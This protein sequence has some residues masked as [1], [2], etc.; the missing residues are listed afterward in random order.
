MNILID[1]VHPAHVHFFK[2]AIAKWRKNGHKVQVVIR[3]K[4]SVVELLEA[5]GIDYIKISDYQP[6]LWGLLKELIGRDI[7]LYKI[8]KKFKPDIMA[9]I[10]GFS[11]SFLGWLT[12]IPAVILTDTEHARLSNFISFPFAALICTPVSFQEDAGKKQLRYNGSHELA[13]LHPDFFTPDKSILNKAGLASDERFFIVRFVSWGAAHDVGEQ[14][15]E[16]E[17]RLGFIEKLSR[18]GKALITSEGKLPDELVKYKIK[19]A[20]QEIH[21]LLYYADLYIGESPTMASEAGVLGTPSILISSWAHEAGCIMEQAQYGI[22]C[23]FTQYEP[24]LKKAIEL[25]GNPKIK[26]KWKQ[27]SRKMVENKISVTPWLVEL[28]EGYAKK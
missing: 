28:V 9:G 16:L 10:A 27:K 6:G 21:H 19:V 20:P 15:I 8:I 11:I 18:Y 24:A 14:G 22:V 1:I 13:Y 3:Q 23:P 7:K 12:N 17:D 26:L 5:Y 2:Y 25:V 4:E